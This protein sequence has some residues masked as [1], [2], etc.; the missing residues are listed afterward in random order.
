MLSPIPLHRSSS[1]RR[2]KPTVNSGE[3]CEGKSNDHNRSCR[4]DIPAEELLF[5]SQLTKDEGVRL[6][7]SVK[8]KLLNKPEKPRIPLSKV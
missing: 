8:S 5:L 4:R 3:S 6:S 7:M 2:E 1:G